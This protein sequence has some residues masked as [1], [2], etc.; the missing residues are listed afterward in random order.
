MVRLVLLAI[1]AF[2]SILQSLTSAPAQPYPTRTVRFIVPFVVQF[3]LYISPVGFQSSIVPDGFRFLYA[4]NPMVGI[5]DGFRWCLLGARNGVFL[6]GIAIAVIEVI[7]LVASGI[8]Y[9]R[10]TEQSFADV[11]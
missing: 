9:F 4:L 11:I 3:G 8:W 5:I 10:K 7:A 2:L 1:I 6:P